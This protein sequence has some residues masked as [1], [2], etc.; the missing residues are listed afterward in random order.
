MMHLLSTWKKPQIPKSFE[1]EDLNLTAKNRPKI[2]Y[3]AAA[4]PTEPTGFPWPAVV[5]MMSF[6]HQGL[7]WS[8]SQPRINIQIGSPQHFLVY[9]YFL[10]K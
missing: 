7:F 10:A 5:Y 8:V 1:N 3:E 6:L 2:Y 9:Y 4:I